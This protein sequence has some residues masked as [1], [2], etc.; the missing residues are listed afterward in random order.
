M[1]QFVKNHKNPYEA[2][3]QVVASLPLSGKTVLVTGGGSGVG[4]HIAQSLAKAGA[5]SIAIV[6]RNKSRIEQAKVELARAYPKTTFSA[7][8]ADVTD[9]NAFR[10]IF[11]TFGAPDILVNNAGHFPDEGP[12]VTQDLRSWFSGFE[13]NILG[14]ANV[15]Q[16]YLQHKDLPKA[17]IVLNVS[18]VAA[19]LRFP[20][21]G[22]SG[23]NGSKMGQARIFENIRFEHPDV[24][25]V[26][27]HPGNIESAG[28][29]RSGAQAPPDGM[30]DGSLAG[31]FFV[32]AATEE[33]D[34]LSGRFV[35]AEW[36]IEELK[37]KR[38][39][40]LEEDLLLTTIDGFVK[41][42]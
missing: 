10:S 5:S 19:H 21:I 35:W 25:F 27:I 8:S 14:T 15:T 29:T 28:F 11:E 20:L 18:S 17:P 12:F 13:I 30:T 23:Y 37:A 24:R 2:L 40:I 42:I 6:G 33:A 1:S 34:F 41:G 38:N 3:S 9:E 32:W 31:D 36:D 16:K 26:N 22:W 39:Q 4:K 7:F